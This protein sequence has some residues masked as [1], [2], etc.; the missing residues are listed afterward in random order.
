MV[1]RTRRQFLADA[2]LLGAAAL[3]AGWT[4]LAQAPEADRLDEPL[5]KLSLAH[6]SFHKAIFGPS[7]NDGAWFQRT[8]HGPDPDQVLQGPMDPRDLAR[9]AR[10]EFGLDAVDYVNQLFFGHA[11]DMPYLR[12]MKQRADDHDVLLVVLMLDQLGNLGDEDDALRRRAI[13]AHRPWMDAAAFLGARSVRVNANGTGSYLGQLHR[14]T[15]SVLQLAEYGDTLGIDVLVENHGGVSNNGAWLN[16]LM[17][18]AEH[19]RVGTMVDFDNF[20]FTDWGERP[21]RRYD[22]YQGMME[23]APFAKAVSAKVIEYDGAG[24]EA[25]IDFHRM[26]RIVLDTGY[27]GYV[28]LEYEGDQMSEMEGMR[29]MVRLMERVRADLTPEYG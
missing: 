7:R 15:D 23:I 6:W 13:E 4:G 29:A 27:R 2:G 10:E 22:R 21:E 1:P 25:N 5:F 24:N 16:M 18:Q 26:M 12:D 28:S 11:T 14:S 17:E 19:P 3:T 8:L 20:M 9:V